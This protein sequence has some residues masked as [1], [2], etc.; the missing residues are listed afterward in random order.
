M[1]ILHLK[2]FLVWPSILIFLLMASSF[3]LKAKLGDRK[4]KGKGTYDE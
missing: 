3:D 1:K 2:T 4:K